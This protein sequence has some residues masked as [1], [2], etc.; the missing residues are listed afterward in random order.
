MS[1][2]HVI[3]TGQ[4]QH[5]APQVVSEQAYVQPQVTL[6][7]VQPVVVQQQQHI[8]PSKGADESDDKDNGD[9]GRHTP[10][11][12]KQVGE[13]PAGSGAARSAL[14]PQ[15]MADRMAEGHSGGTG[16]RNNMTEKGY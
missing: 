4:T 2:K 10:T 12:E 9:L 7:P 6:Q 13:I 14:T 16:E 11:G 15:Q 8:A 5:I 1:D 3:S